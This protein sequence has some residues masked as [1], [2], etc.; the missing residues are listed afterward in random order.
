MKIKKT[1]LACTLGLGL[2]ISSTTAASA[3]VVARDVETASVPGTTNKLSGTVSI[4]K[5]S[6][7]QMSTYGQTYL[8]NFLSG[9]A[10]VDS[11]YVKVTACF[12]NC[13]TKSQTTNKGSNV[14]SVSFSQGAYSKSNPYSATG[15][16]SAKKG[17]KVVSSTPG[18]STHY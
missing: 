16:H 9:S 5:S 7:N 2:A 11:L 8:A 1:L 6:S 3:A 18:T 4:S 15:S 12:T 17:G 10:P 14:P 13:S